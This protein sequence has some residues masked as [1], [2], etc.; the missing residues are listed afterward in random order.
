MPAGFSSS[1]V[2]SS[3]LFKIYS[4]RS[5]LSFHVRAQTF[6]IEIQKGADR[7]KPRLLDECHEWL[8]IMRQLEEHSHAMAWTKGAGPRTEKALLA[9]LRKVDHTKK[10]ERLVA[11]FEDVMKACPWPQALAAKLETVQDACL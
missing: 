6:I 2:L 9:K 1:T 10:P 11:L 5:S 4:R 3:F 7:D 8:Q